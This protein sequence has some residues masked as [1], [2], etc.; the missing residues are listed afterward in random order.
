[1]LEPP[2]LWE[3]QTRAK[4][5]QFIDSLYE[6]NK[7]KNLTRVP[8]EEAWT[9]HILDSLAMSE[10]V[11]PGMTVLD[12]GTGPGVPGWVLA[13]V[14]PE[15]RVVAL[16]SNKKMVDHMRDLPL[17]NLEICTDRAE[18]V[19]RI[20]EEEFDLVTG[21]AFAPLGVFLE[22]GCRFVKTGGMMAPFRTPND[23]EEIEA[24]PAKVLGLA[25]ESV[26]KVDV[27]DTEVQRVFPVYRKLQRTPQ[28][29]PRTWA[30]IKRAPLTA[31]HWAN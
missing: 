15:I 13:C 27:P 18:D 24:F 19:A 23:L 29:Y 9:R 8:R 2:T 26:L 1:M 12:L 28:K 7:V 11:S 30:E 14:Y 4:L 6:R 17:P 25:L 21:R 16:D 5:D 10:L 31:Y 3:E 22:T 20:M